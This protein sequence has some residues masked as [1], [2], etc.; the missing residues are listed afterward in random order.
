MDWITQKRSHKGR[1]CFQ[2]RKHEGKT[3]SPYDFR[4]DCYKSIACFM[5][6]P[7]LS[8]LITGSTERHALGA[9]RTK[10]ASHVQSR[11]LLLRFNV[12]IYFSLPSSPNLCVL[13]KS[14]DFFLYSCRRRIL[15]SIPSI[16]VLVK[17]ITFD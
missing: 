7:F 12:C 2:W 16:G 10:N 9:C 3:L 13:T 5:A 11:L 17:A 6:L 15:L 8:A 1:Y 4:K 14:I